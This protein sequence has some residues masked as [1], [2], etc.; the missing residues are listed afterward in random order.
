MNAS[1]LK[2][3]NRL[4]RRVMIT[5]QQLYQPAPLRHHQEPPPASDAVVVVPLRREL[6][7]DDN[8][9]HSDD[10]RVIKQDNNNSEK[11]DIYE[12]DRS[13]R[14]NTS[15]HVASHYNS[16]SDG[17]LNNI[18]SNSKQQNGSANNFTRS[19]ESE[20][21]LQRAK[22]IIAQRSSRKNNHTSYSSPVASPS[23][24]VH[25]A[26][27]DT[28]GDNNFD[29]SQTT[30]TRKNSARKNNTAAAAAAAST[31]G[32][33][34][35]RGGAAVP[36]E[37]QRWPQQTYN[38]RV[39]SNANNNSTSPPQG[40]DEM[41]T[42]TSI[43]TDEAMEDRNSM[44][45]NVIQWERRMQL[46]RQQQHQQLK[47]VP[48]SKNEYMKPSL[49]EEEGEGEGEGDIV[50]LVDEAIAINS[51]G[52]M[53]NKKSTPP[54]TI[55]SMQTPNIYYNSTLKTVVITP[56]DKQLQ[57]RN[58]SSNNNNYYSHSNSL[59][60]PPPPPPSEE[61]EEVN[62]PSPAPTDHSAD[63]AAGMMFALHGKSNSG[64][65]GSS[66]GGSVRKKVGSSTIVKNDEQER[67][68]GAHSSSTPTPPRLISPSSSN[69]DNHKQSTPTATTTPITS[70]P[71]SRHQPHRLNLEQKLGRLA[72]TTATPSSNHSL[73]GGAT[74]KVSVVSIQPSIESECVRQN[75]E[76]L[77]AM[78]DAMM[79]F[80]V[81]GTS[82]GVAAT[83]NTV[84]SVDEKGDYDTN[85]DEGGV[86]NEERL[87]QA[88]S[89]NKSTLL[90]EEETLSTN[91]SGSQNQLPLNETD[92]DD[93]FP[94]PSPPFDFDD[95]PLINSDSNSISS[96]T[97]SR[98]INH[99]DHQAPGSSSGEFIIPNQQQQQS[100]TTGRK[101]DKDLGT[102]LDQL[103]S[104][105]G[106]QCAPDRDED[107]DVF[108]M[109]NSQFNTSLFNAADFE[110]LNQR[111]MD[112]RVIAEEQ[113]G[114]KRDVPTTT[115]SAI[116][117]SESFCGES[118]T[119]MPRGNTAERRDQVAYLSPPRNSAPAFQFARHDIVGSDDP[120]D[121]DL[122]L[123]DDDDDDDDDDESNCL[124]DPEGDSGADDYR[125]SGR[126]P[127]RGIDPEEGEDVLYHRNRFQNQRPSD[128][129][130]TSTR[131]KQK[132]GTCTETNATQLTPTR[133]KSSE[134]IEAATS[135]LPSISANATLLQ[136]HFVENEHKLSPNYRRRG[137][138]RLQ[139][140]DEVEEEEDE[141]DDDAS[142]PS[143]EENS[144]GPQYEYEQFMEDFRDIVQNDPNSTTSEPEQS[145]EELVIGSISESDSVKNEDDDL[146]ENAESRNVTQRREVEAAM[147]RSLRQASYNRQ[148]KYV[149]ND[150]KPELVKPQ[151]AGQQKELHATQS[152]GQPGKRVAVKQP[153]HKAARG[154]QYKRPQTKVAAKPR[155]E[156]KLRGLGAPKKLSG[157]SVATSEL[158]SLYS[159]SAAAGV[160]KTV[161]HRNNPPP[162]SSM[163]NVSNQEARLRALDTL[164]RGLTPDLSSHAPQ[165][166]SQPGHTAVKGRADGKNTLGFIPIGSETWELKHEFLDSSPINP[167]PRRSPLGFFRSSNDE[168]SQVSDG[169][170]RLKDNTLGSLQVGTETWNLKYD[171]NDSPANRH[172]PFD[173]PPQQQQIER[174]QHSPT[175]DRHLEKIPSRPPQP[176][177]SDPINRHPPKKLVIKSSTEIRNGTQVQTLRF[178]GREESPSPQQHLPPS[179]RS[180]SGKKLF[181]SVP[182]AAKVARSAPPHQS[183]QVRR[184]VAKSNQP[185]Q[186]QKMLKTERRHN[187][188]AQI[189]TRHTTNNPAPTRSLEENLRRVRSID[190][191]SSETPTF[192][193]AE[194]SQV[195]G[196]VFEAVEVGSFGVQHMLFSKWDKPPAPPQRKAPGVSY[197]STFNGRGNQ[198][199][200]KLNAPRSNLGRFRRK[201]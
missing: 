96:S 92:D 174:R 130:P 30:P 199:V 141:E 55:Q 167:Q 41:S 29:T 179:T 60:P 94:D 88:F 119:T 115:T 31:M 126:D 164:T 101:K 47:T 165:K 1:N 17:R 135:K 200:A 54:P 153:L 150:P 147:Q 138:G 75:A 172:D 24:N 49:S 36:K 161:F 95:P 105:F 13:G 73:H 121:P 7:F 85:E 58:H 197:V 74:S 34:N 151:I 26:S 82:G 116:H 177:R 97:T 3:R 48:L 157:D 14:S 83:M 112:G 195:S 90:P 32:V 79:D 136:E 156:E 189:G 102:F 114:R 191:P 146:D 125:G 51:A 100:N 64:S 111:R 201:K 183:Q 171:F 128:A 19:K 181:Q 158:G 33:I 11:C 184:L 123:Q 44:I 134:E 87:N 170:G 173:H 110:Q 124:P 178:V 12:H 106:V 35:H 152:S 63:A 145:V 80:L 122:L 52:A 118:H 21:M 129:S 154:N 40:H 168:G 107:S 65:S 23:R 72:T 28:H 132:E 131:E 20:A 57:N 5:R 45:R 113:D 8:N 188:G 99:H 50:N 142:D 81:G 169:F 37:Q 193:E 109:N 162:S 22:E 4:K 93:D 160:P 67:Y 144:E 43:L 42:T 190:P 70:T 86:N 103:S 149:Q 6:L 27:N 9:V 194:A 2:Y 59:L 84:Q 78:E 38:K 117:S 198:V 166:L 89:R 127:P 137:G 18:N 140:I 120:P 104:L 69:G 77:V 108:Y 10:A 186:G 62:P 155:L 98:S 192:P 56:D 66:S 175:V 76:I 180:L 182:S 187:Q 39:Y 53:P 71:R 185:M 139:F 68:E 25:V 176:A 133:A 15:N 16:R 196:S 143:V 163:Q 46:K 91:D 148:R 61:N 159:A